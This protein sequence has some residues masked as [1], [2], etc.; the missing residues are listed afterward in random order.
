MQVVGAP[1]NVG[2]GGCEPWL[3]EDEII[4]FERVEEGVEVISEVVAGEG[5][6]DGVLSDGGGAV[7]KDNGNGVAGME[8]E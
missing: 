4:R 1:V 6:G 2:V 7:R 5:N 8:G 3:P